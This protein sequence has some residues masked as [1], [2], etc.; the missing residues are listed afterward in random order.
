MLTKISPGFTLTRELTYFVGISIISKTY[1]E[2]IHRTTTKKMRCHKSCYK[3]DAIIRCFS[4]I[5]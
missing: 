5:R 4:F 2:E 3:S 1:L